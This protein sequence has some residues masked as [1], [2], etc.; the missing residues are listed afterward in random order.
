ML[1][2]K[3]KAQSFIQTISA[4]L[5]LSRKKEIGE[6]LNFYFFCSSGDEYIQQPS[7]EIFNIP[8]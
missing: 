6:D 4:P 1:G 3:R 2:A 5:S 8:I 7:K